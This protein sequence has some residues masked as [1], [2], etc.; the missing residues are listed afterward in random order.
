MEEPKKVSRKNAEGLDRFLPKK[1][2]GRP[3]IHRDTV[4]GTADN[5]RVRL[6]QIWDA[7]GDGLLQAKTPKEVIAAFEGVGVSYRS[8]FVPVAELILKVIQEPTFPKTPEAQIRFLADSLG[9][10]GH[11]SA[12]RSRD[13]CSA[14]RK[15]VVYWIMRQDFYIQCSCGYEGPALRGACPNCK[16]NRLHP[17]ALAMTEEPVQSSRPVT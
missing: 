8:H 3:G 13:I 2:R 12:R 1:P 11:R 6:S 9:A 7:V 16:T 17:T 5:D 15:K 4:R 10:R 14:E